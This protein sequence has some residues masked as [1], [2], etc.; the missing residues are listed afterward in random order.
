M[1]VCMCVCVC[2]TY[3]YILY[4][5]KRLNLTAYDMYIDIFQVKKFRYVAASMGSEP[6][7]EGLQVC[8]DNWC[9]KIPGLVNSHISRTGK[10]HHAFF[11]G[12]STI[13]TGPFSIANCQFT[14]GYWRSAGVSGDTAS[15]LQRKVCCS[16]CF[17]EVLSYMFL[18][19]SCKSLGLFV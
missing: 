11:M 6:V 7:Q 4:N 3:I 10:I 2:N 5:F 13:S 9:R 19:R 12:K 18:V 16:K 1:Y 17:L 15:F 14:R 8:L